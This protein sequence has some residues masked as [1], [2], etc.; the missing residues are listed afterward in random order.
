[1]RLK[2][3][4]LKPIEIQT[5]QVNEPRIEIYKG[6]DLQE[7]ENIIG[8]IQFLSWVGTEDCFKEKITGNYAIQMMGIDAMETKPSQPKV[9][10]Y[11][12]MKQKVKSTDVKDGNEV[13]IKDC[14]KKNGTKKRT[15]K[16]S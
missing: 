9:N 8:K 10:H 14:Q 12:F 15:K 2:I 6:N 5:M 16:K 3:G 4:Q 11:K 1:M 7:R 13:F